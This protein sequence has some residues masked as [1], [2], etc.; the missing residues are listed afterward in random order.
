MQNTRRVYRD[1][2]IAGATEEMPQRPE[3][4]MVPYHIRQKKFI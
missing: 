4:K 3:F 1:V 2:T